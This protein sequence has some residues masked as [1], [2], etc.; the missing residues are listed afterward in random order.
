VPVIVTIEVP[1]VAEPDALNVNV[2][3]LVE[4]VGLKEAVT[5]LGK[6]LAEKATV[7]VKPL[8]GTTLTVTVPLALCAT[9]RLVGAAVRLKLG[10]ALTVRLTATDSVKLP[11]VPMTVTTELP[12]AAVDAALNVS[13]V[14]PEELVGLKEAVTPLGR[15]LAE[16][17]TVPVKPFAGTTVIVEVAVA[18]GATLTLAGFAVKLKFGPVSR[19]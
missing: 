3:A 9:V 12:I 2:V 15:P 6:P 5:P 17:V 1:V 11:E 7:P 19:P 8:E 10:A 18:P 4:L 16:K 13:V 14:V